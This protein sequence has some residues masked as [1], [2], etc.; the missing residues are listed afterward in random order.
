MNRNAI[1][2]KLKA[3]FTKLTNWNDQKQGVESTLT[4]NTVTI[5]FDDTVIRWRFADDRARRAFQYG[6]D[7][8]M[9]ILRAGPVRDYVEA[10]DFYGE[11]FDTPATDL[12]NG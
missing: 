2:K 6:L 5:T 9:F 4:K 7:G 3:I 1:Y 8:E 11:P 10:S 12:V